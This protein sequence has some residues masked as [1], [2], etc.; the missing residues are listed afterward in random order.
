M[1][2]VS[3]VI[4]TYNSAVYL[5]E[6]VRS[7]L[8][9]TYPH[10]ESL[11][12]DDG[13][14]DGTPAAVQ[15]FGE[16]VRLFQQDRAGPSVARNRA[17][18]HARGT[19]LA[20]LDADDVWLPAKLARQVD[21][22]NRHPEV[23]L[24]YTDYCRGPGGSAAGESQLKHHVHPGLGDA[25]Y[26]LFR[27]NFIHTS[28]VVVRRDALARSG[29]FDPSLR[30][31]EDIELW[32]R[33]ACLGPFGAVEEVLVSVRRHAANTTKSLDFVRHQVGAT[34]LML[35]RWGK[36]AAAARLLRQRLGRCCWDLAYAEMAHGNYKRARAAYWESVRHGHRRAGGLARAA[37][38]TLPRGLVSMV[39]KPAKP[40]AG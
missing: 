19:Y 38:L 25:F 30:G 14:T 26:P 28:S 11:I 8:A 12:V 24:C 10:V 6:A 4:P 22:L 20:F 18:L 33:L 27:N 37:L 39:K 13:S 16:R 21:F 36:D 9:Q 2:L 31:S 7:V 35:L 23:V 1:D 15:P 17:I 29:L 40:L 3:V 34:R 32:L 5:V